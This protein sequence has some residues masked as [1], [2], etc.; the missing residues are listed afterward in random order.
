MWFFLLVV[1][2]L[3]A[4]WNFYPRVKKK[5]AGQTVLIT[6]GAGGIGRLM[7]HRFAGLGCHVVLWDLSQEGVDRVAE[8]CEARG[9]PSAKGWVVDI[10]NYEQVLKNARI[11]EKEF[12]K[13]EILINNA[14]VVSGKT[15]TDLH[16][17]KIEQVFAVNVF[18]VFWALQAFL[19][20]MYEENA[21]HIVT[22]SSASAVQGVAR[23]VDYSSS[24]FAAYGAMD[25]LRGEIRR[26]GKTGV[27][28]TVVCPYYID[29]GMF[30]GASKAS[31]LLPILKPDYVADSVVEA[32]LTDTAELYLPAIV[33]I[34]FLARLLP[35]GLR[36][37]IDRMFFGLGST[38]DDFK[39][40][41]AI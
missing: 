31:L 2:A 8:E 41:R 14:G 32:V 34:G 26:L 33:R 11:V 30:E 5:V 23:L 19:P 29:T 9:S 15:V 13:V 17:H 7:A 24:K 21:G 18:G 16:P 3:I 22:I 6:G 36:D 25:A 28:T 10:T 37:Q 4:L 39:G 1:V 20:K 35:C 40:K 38:M 12:G 27:K